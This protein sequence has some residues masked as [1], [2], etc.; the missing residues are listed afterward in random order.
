MKNV[1]RLFRRSSKQKIIRSA[2][3]VEGVLLLAI[4]VTAE[5]KLGPAVRSLILA[6]TSS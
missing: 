4:A 6:Y 1:K 5:A 2:A 3:M